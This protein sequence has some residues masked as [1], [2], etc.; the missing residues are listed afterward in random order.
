M[1]DGTIRMIFQRISLLNYFYRPSVP[2]YFH[3]PPLAGGGVAERSRWELERKMKSFSTSSSGG[4]G[5]VMMAR[6]TTVQV[7][8]RGRSSLQFVIILTRLELMSA[9]I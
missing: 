4:G 8:R 2:N 1:S 6:V 3:F 9:R 5:G 7:S